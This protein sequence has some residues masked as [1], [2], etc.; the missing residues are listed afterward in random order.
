MGT[1][2]VKHPTLMS[3]YSPCYWPDIFFGSR[4]RPV[5]A[6][7]ASTRGMQSSRTR[8]ATRPAFLFTIVWIVWQ[9][10]RTHMIDPDECVICSISQFWMWYV[11]YVYT[12]IELFINTELQNY[13]AFGSFLNLVSV[14][15]SR[16]PLAICKSVGKNI[17]FAS[18]F[19]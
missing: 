19:F 16:I 7:W 10:S 15:T 9:Q 3:P 5:G 14:N 18:L 1:I 8:N 11:V 6:P 13:Y 2:S 4:T 12:K 17:D